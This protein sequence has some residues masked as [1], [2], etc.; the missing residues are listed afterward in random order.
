MLAEHESVSIKST[1]EKLGA[2]SR[3]I[4][5]YVLS[6][7]IYYCLLRYYQTLL[8]LIPRH[9]TARK[10]I[11]LLNT[12]QVYI[13]RKYDIITK[14]VN[15]SD[16]VSSARSRTLGNIKDKT[17]SRLMLLRNTVNIDLMSIK[18]INL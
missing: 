15:L 18:N 12:Y 14:F 8:K 7:I 11:N 9:E 5:H 2:L 17:L 10:M 1:T 3:I 16:Q 13:F 6:P 4:D